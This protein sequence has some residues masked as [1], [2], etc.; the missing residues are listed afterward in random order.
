MDTLGS[1][2]VIVPY[3]NT[4][5]NARALCVP[6]F[7]YSTC[8]YLS[9]GAMYYINCAK[10]QENK[11]SQL[12]VQI[13]MNTGSIIADAPQSLSPVFNP[14]I[15]VMSCLKKTCKITIANS[16]VINIESAEG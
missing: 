16:V 5:A 4:P 15:L 2:S 14:A 12:T 6:V 3:N 10:P 9:R 7:G 8:D 13:Q 11:T 1:V